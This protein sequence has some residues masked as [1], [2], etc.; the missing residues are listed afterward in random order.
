LSGEVYHQIIARQPISLRGNGGI[1]SQRAEKLFESSSCNLLTLMTDWGLPQVYK[2]PKVSAGSLA[3][4]GIAVSDHLIHSIVRSSDFSACPREAGNALGSRSVR[5]T[6]R[7]LAK[8]TQF[9][10]LAVAN[11]IDLSASTL[12]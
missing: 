6:D 9:A 10:G 8:P 5:V 11:P 2:N 4:N 1:I 3:S 12:L 7:L